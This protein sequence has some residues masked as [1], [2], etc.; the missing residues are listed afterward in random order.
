[1][2]WRR[3]DML[4][5]A[6]AALSIAQASPSLARAPLTTRYGYND[7]A[8]DWRVFEA[9]ARDAAKSGKPIFFLVHATWCHHCLS[10][11]TLF[12][13]DEVVR[14]LKRFTPVLVDAD[15]QPELNKRYAPTGPYVP[16]TMF[17]DA[18]A[19]LRKDLHLPYP[20]HEYFVD[21]LDGPKDLRRLLAMAEAQF[22]GA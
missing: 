21:Y 8:I 7:A 4:V 19:R 1:M 22:F 10:Y 18:Q 13:D 17:L 12:F 6:G 3:R 15:A 11:R 20:E 2:A 9:G 16:R 5:G 14:R